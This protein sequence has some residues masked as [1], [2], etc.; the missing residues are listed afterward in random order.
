VDSSTQITALLGHTGDSGDVEVINAGGTATLGG[1]TFTSKTDL[2]L[3]TNTLSEIIYCANEASAPESFQVSGTGLYEDLVI[4]APAGFE[5]SLVSDSGYTNSVTLTPS[6]N[7][8]PSTTL[9]VRT[10]SGQD[11]ELSGNINVTS[12]TSSE[13]IAISSA[14]NNALYFDGEDDFVSLNANTIEDGATDF[15]I[16]TWILPD[17]SN[18]DGEYHAIIGKEAVATNMR[19]PSFYIHSGNVHVDMYEDETL[20]RYDFLTEDPIVLQNV[21][22]HMA[23]VKEGLEYRFFVNGEL[24]LSREESCHPD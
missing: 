12:G 20:N 23:L 14:T 5:I 3:S 9:Y 16:E 13:D 22:T 17:N 7:T 4:T 21:W 6:S 8:V 10:A 24:I 11:G 19:N 18:W 15:T 2:T 1:F